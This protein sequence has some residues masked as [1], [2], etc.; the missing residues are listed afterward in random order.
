MIQFYRAILPYCYRLTFDY[1]HG[2]K[3]NNIST[4]IK[5]NT[6]YTNV[7][8]S[9]HSPEHLKCAPEIVPKDLVSNICTHIYYI[10]LF[11]L[12]MYIFFLFV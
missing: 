9:Y 2:T 10:Q 8:C 5:L 7:L 12:D 1:E 4:T 3:N 6:Y 11:L